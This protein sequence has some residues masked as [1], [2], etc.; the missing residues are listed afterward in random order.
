MGVDLQEVLLSEIDPVRV[1]AWRSLDPQRTTRSTPAEVT[2]LLRLIWRDE[3][4]PPEACAEVRRIMALQVWPHRLTAGFPDNVTVAGK[5]GSLPGIRNEAG[6]VV[7]PD[8]RRYAVGVFTRAEV[9]AGR[10]PRVDAAIGAAA[11]AAVEM[12]RA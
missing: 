10:T 6:V 5:T 11:C 2:K 7:Y 8:G 9:Y 4:G 12:L 1:R 3:A